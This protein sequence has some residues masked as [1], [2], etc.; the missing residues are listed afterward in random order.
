MKIIA[1][2]A[3]NHNGSVDYLIELAKESEKAGA[4]FFTLQVM[5]V[6]DFCSEDYSKYE[7]YK[8]YSI[9]FKDLDLFFEEARSLNI[10]IIVCVLDVSSFNYIY[11]KGFRF[12]KIHATDISN[13]ALLDLINTKED[14]S[15]IL[16]TQCATHFD[17]NYA[18]NKLKNKI[19]C[20]I[21]GFS[22][23]PTEVEDL[24]LNSLDYLKEK[25][26]LPIGFADH[27][28][29]QQ[30]VPLMALAK[31]CS[32][33]EKHI[34]LTRNNRN[35]DYQVSMYPNEFAI[36]VASIKHY[37]KALGVFKKHPTPS[38]NEFRRIMYKKTQED[39]TFKRSDS[40]DESIV[41]QIKSFD[42][43]NVG[44]ALIARLKSKRLERKVLKPLFDTVLIDFLYNRIS[45]NKFEDKV[46]L[47]TS[48]YY[49]DDELANYAIDNQL[50]LFRGHAESVID[51]M[52]QLSFEQGFGA[53]FRVTGDNP[54]TDP[55][56]M[57]EMV[58]LYLDNKLDYVRVENVPFGISAELFST[59][60]L[61][62]LYM[63]L[64]NPMNSEYLTWY[65]LN[66]ETARKGVVKVNTDI[67]DA[68]LYNFSVDYKEDYEDVIKVISKLDKPYSSTTKEILKNVK[69]IKKVDLSKEIKLPE[70]TSI[71][72]Y[73][74]LEMLK[75]QTL[76]IK[77]E[78]K[79]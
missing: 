45:I 15:I 69:G 43:K 11:L 67:E 79:L 12:L 53:V 58:E 16:E 54:L 44:I 55:F 40:G 14:V 47:A 27:S 4:D 2:S 72:F 42:K 5:D 66:D 3:F 23:Y 24:Q 70:S 18:I 32:F 6:D 76:I 60:Y 38:E 65:V 9:N 17:I 20:L 19:V 39:G 48:D 34:T 7:L 59:E 74:Y 31:G 57:Q 28:L 41:K 78:I 61:W 52:L 29:D 25:F 64:N 13:E 73:D 62:K 50:N 8:K 75:N 51:R 22:N 56:L 21:H 68:S 35:L 46:F 37:E 63:E 1:E 49:T 33:L 26:N 10:E 77:K 36:M 71:L 30:N